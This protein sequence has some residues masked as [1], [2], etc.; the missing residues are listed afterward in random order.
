MN[1]LEDY[2]SS[3][4]QAWN[5]FYW[6]QQPTIFLTFTVDAG[7]M[8][9]R[10]KGLTLTHTGVHAGQDQ[11][12]RIM[13]FHNHPANGR[14]SVVTLE[15]FAAGRQVNF[16]NERCTFDQ[17]TVWERGI[18][19]VRLGSPYHLFFN[20]CQHTSSDIC[21]GQKKSPDLDFWKGLLLIGAGVLA[22]NALANTK[23]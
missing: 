8:L 23:S 17:K 21:H 16:T 10:G 14:T 6:N 20:N 22:I 7:K 12:G 1:F 15:E 5:N 18:E 9:R 13:V 3:Q 4:N 19:A 2:L 11:Y